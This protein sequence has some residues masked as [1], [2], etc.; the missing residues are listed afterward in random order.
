MHT[1]YYVYEYLREDGSPYYV[2]KGRCGRHKERHNVPIPPEDRIKVAMHVE[3]VTE[4]FNH[5]RA[6]LCE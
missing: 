2:G 1:D 5:L 3:V 4:S 6:P